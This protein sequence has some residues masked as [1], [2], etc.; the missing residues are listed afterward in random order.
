MKNSYKGNRKIHFDYHT[1]PD[2]QEVASSFE[3][4]TLMKDLAEIGCELINFFAKDLFGNCYWNTKVGHKHPYLKRDLLKEVTEA[5][6]KYG[7][8]IVA[9]YNVMDLYNVQAHPELKHRGCKEVQNS[10]GDYVCLNSPWL[11]KVLLPELKEISSYEVSGIFFD[12][13]YFHQPCFCKW[14]EQ[15]FMDEFSYEIP[16]DTKSNEWKTYTKWL[17]KRGNE[18]VR[19]VCETIHEVNSKILVG[20]NWAYVQRQPETPPD[21]I[22]FITLDVNETDCTSL[23]ASYY[24][25][26]LRT[27]NKPFDIMTTRFL[28]WWGDWALKPVTTMKH[29]CAVIL[30]NGG[31]CIIGDHFYIDGKHE[32][33]VIKNISN[34]FDFV[35]KRETILDEASSVPFIAVLHSAENSYIKGNG[36]VADEKSTRGAHKLFLECNL[37]FD[38]LN[39]EGLISN[40]D[41][42]SLVVIPEQMD[43]SETLITK[44]KDYVKAGGK[45]LLSYDSSKTKEELDAQWTKELF[46]ISLKNKDS[47]GFGYIVPEVS[48]LQKNLPRM[49][50]FCRSNFVDI[51]EKTAKTLASKL[52]AYTT[53]TSKQGWEGWLGAGIGSPTFDR[54]YPTITLNEFGNGKTVFLGCEIFKAYFEYN[55]WTLRT[56]VMN[57]IDLL[58]PEKVIEVSSPYPIEVTLLKKEESYLINLI[59]WHSERAYKTPIITE[60]LPEINNITINLTLD[61]APKN[62]LV[63]P[64]DEEHKI[65]WQWNG[66]KL[67]IRVGKLH[68][69]SILEVRT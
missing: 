39:E 69:H 58:L 61:K 68:I 52:D 44:I 42:Y 2:F 49:P 24:A 50:I 65:E 11:E 64:E 38:I 47:L 17:R 23:N 45:L 63:H 1:P 15:K 46:G 19:K 59:N 33:E 57:A 67:K 18:I 12:F 32:K 35:S 22:G 16:K 13:L 30:A 53:I 51:E 7:I 26:Y 31:Q 41:K 55:D 3:P 48:D 5:S 28:H 62:V 60:N 27:L 40:I 25:K 54:R 6:K 37:H 29:E 34:V 4:E 43:L 10:E 36:I 8:K 9:Y 56:I 66:N 21:D 14:C 20:V